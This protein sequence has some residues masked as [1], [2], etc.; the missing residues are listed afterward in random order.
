M[1]DSSPTAA[2][3]P[4]ACAGPSLLALLS[5]GDCTRMVHAPS[6]TQQAKSLQLLSQQGLLPTAFV[7]L[8]RSNES[9]GT[10]EIQFHLAMG[11]YARLSSLPCEQNVRVSRVPHTMLARASLGTPCYTPGTITVRVRRVRS[12]PVCSTLMQANSV[13]WHLLSAKYGFVALQ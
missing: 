7:G 11:N 13:M 5:S 3:W 6:M 4:L 10:F 2:P 12:L 9:A 8:V 1:P